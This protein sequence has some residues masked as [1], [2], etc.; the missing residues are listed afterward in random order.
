MRVTLQTC[1]LGFALI[2]VLAGAARSQDRQAEMWNGT[3]WKEF[4]REVKV[5]Y[6]KGVGNMADLEVAVSGK[7]R[8][9]CLAI[10][11]VRDLKDKSIEEIVHEVDKFYKQNPRMV[12]T[13]VVDA[14]IRQC[15]SLC[16]PAPRAAP[17]KK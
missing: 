15:P 11:L 2:L 16:K 8:G 6:I 9:G 13:P 17:V 4:S 10:G 1:L 14:V 12:S 7:A 3:H 5:A